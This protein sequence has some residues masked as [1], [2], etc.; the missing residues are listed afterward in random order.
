MIFGFAPTSALPQL[1]LLHERVR[2]LWSDADG[3][4]AENPEFCIPVV[5]GRRRSDDISDV[6]LQLGWLRAG[7]LAEYHTICAVQR[8]ITTSTPE[9]LY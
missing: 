8:A 2:I 3:P 5:S 4:C 9:Y 6:I 7:E 1:P